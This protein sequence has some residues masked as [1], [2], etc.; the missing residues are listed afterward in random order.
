MDTVFLAIKVSCRLTR[1]LTPELEMRF[2]K[3]YQAIKDVVECC[4]EIYED[5]EISKGCGRDCCG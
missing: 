1:S 5:S 2:P 3:T 4:D